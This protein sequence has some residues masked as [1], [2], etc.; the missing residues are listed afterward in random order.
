MHWCEWDSRTE[1][2]HG[3]NE[4]TPAI[5]SGSRL[6]RALRS[7]PGRSWYG[8]VTTRVADAPEGKFFAVVHDLGDS[9]IAQVYCDESKTGPAELVS[10]IPAERRAR[11]RDE[12]AFEF[13]S[14]CR[15]LNALSAGAE[16]QVHEAIAAA[17]AETPASDPLIFSVNSGTWPSDL[18]HVLSACVEE[19]AVAM[20]QWMSAV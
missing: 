14:F 5:A 12:F 9:A 2:W 15:F 8:P 20:C 11:L 3:P 19:L 17:M 16:F 10:V 18:D 13:I 7:A 4:L 6:L 1:T